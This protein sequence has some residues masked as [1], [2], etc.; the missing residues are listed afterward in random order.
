MVI[1]EGIISL[2]L[3]LLWTWLL[4][5]VGAQVVGSKEGSWKNCAILI[6][7]FWAVAAAVIF[8]AIITSSFNS[9]IF[10]LFLIITLFLVYFY[11][12]MKILDISFLDSVG[13]AI[14]TGGFNWFVFFLLGKLEGILPGVS[15]ITSHVSFWGLTFSM[16]TH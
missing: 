10:M 12:A 1:I 9:F 14:L 5:R 16:T 6:G 11:L 3:S 13:L 7:S 8:L 4:L 2:V 15:F